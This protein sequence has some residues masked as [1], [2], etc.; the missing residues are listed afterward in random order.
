M[1]KI[2][3]LALFPCTVSAQQLI[4]K[5]VICGQTET[6]IKLLVGAEY[7]EK[8]IW[9]GKS[10]EDNKFSLFLNKDTATWTLIEFNS[11][12]A[13]ILGSGSESL[14]AKNILNKN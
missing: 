13:C 14:L 4:S 6:I 5:P 7:E 12:V 3:L 1:K 8:P 10:A 2:L 11:K 9:F